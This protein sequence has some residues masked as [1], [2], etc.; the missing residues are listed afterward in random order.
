MNERGCAFFIF[1]F[2]MIGGII[3]SLF[4]NVGNDNR[5]T[6]NTSNDINFSDITIYTLPYKGYYN[7]DKKY[8]CPDIEIKDAIDQYFEVSIK[9]GQKKNNEQKKLLS[10]NASNITNNK[11]IDNP[12]YYQKNKT[13]VNNLHISES[14][15]KET[16]D[17]DI[18]NTT[19]NSQLAI[20]QKN[21]QSKNIDVKYTYGEKVQSSIFNQIEFG[22]EIEKLLKIEEILTKLKKDKE[23]MIKVIDDLPIGRFEKN[24][25][26]I[27]P[28]SC[29]F[30]YISNKY[31]LR[32]NLEKDA[33]YYFE[34]Q[35]TN[36]VQNYADS[37]NLFIDGNYFINPY[38]FNRFYNTIV[39]NIINMFKLQY[40]FTHSQIEISSIS[41]LQD[42]STMK[43]D[44]EAGS[45]IKR[46]VSLHET[47]S[48]KDTISSNYI[49]EYNIGGLQSKKLV[50]FDFTFEKLFTTEMFINIKHKSLS[51]IKKH[52]SSIKVNAMNT[53]KNELDKITLY[54]DKNTNVQFFVV[55]S[56]TG[57]FVKKALLDKNKDLF[58]FDKNDHLYEPEIKEDNYRWNNKKIKNKKS[59]RYKLTPLKKTPNTNKIIPYR[60]LNDIHNDFIKSMA[61]YLQTKEAERKKKPLKIASKTK[62]K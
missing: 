5:Q 18:K 47:E 11:N 15:I 24:E 6:N 57:E 43:I 26:F 12:I 54:D 52:L 61:D 17:Y 28:V 7:Y 34:I 33:R 59:L 9:D 4:S 27:Q 19:D 46:P 1:V 29:V 13:V 62:K 8:N 3:Y 42:L 30:K 22:K 23:L 14:P 49:N 21:N 25:H 56:S 39:D 2:L 32:I 20:T 48:E 37:M 60:E 35:L 38:N 16:T 10:K 36:F 45:Y 31:N 58:Q 55:H 53:V 44:S 50:F 41:S 40:H 51:E